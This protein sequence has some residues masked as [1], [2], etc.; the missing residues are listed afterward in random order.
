MSRCIRFPPPGY[1]W[2][3]V[4]GEALIELIKEEQVGFEEIR[5]GDRL[6][7]I[8]FLITWFQMKLS[9]GIFVR[10]VRHRSEDDDESSYYQAKNE[11]EFRRTERTGLTEELEQP[12]ILDSLCDSF[13]TSHS[14][15][16]KGPE[17]CHKYGSVFWIDIRLQGHEDRELEFGKPVWSITATDFLVQEK[18]EFP[19]SC[20]RE[21]FFSTCSESTSNAFE[22]DRPGVEFELQHT[23]LNLRELVVNW[24]P[25]PM[26]SENPEFDN[27]GWLCETK[28]ERLPRNDYT[29]IYRAGT[30]RLSHL[31]SSLYPTAQYLSQ[32]EI[33]A[34][35]FA[36]PF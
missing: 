11:H 18:S 15:R 31:I 25:L 32:A 2:N 7:V 34:L 16:R 12:S 4:K 3:G 14:D 19:K 9:Y 23:E 30:D 20:T 21:Q 29:K 35:P 6:V 33:Y 28:P 24:I 36:I 1:V 10:L 22:S 5:E 27:L 17:R 8:S 26:K 13:G